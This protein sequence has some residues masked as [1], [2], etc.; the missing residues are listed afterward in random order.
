VQRRIPLLLLSAALAGCH[1]DSGD[2]RE[3]EIWVVDFLTHASDI[4]TTMTRVDLDGEAV[5]ERA[6]EYLRS[7]YYGIPIVFVRGLSTAD[8]RTSSICVRNTF[9]LNYGHGFLDVGNRSAVH[10]CGFEPSGL[11]GAFVN[12]VAD[13]Y[14]PQVTPTMTRNERT[15]AFAH[16]LGV[17][18]AHE[19]GH[20]LG[21]AH[22]TREFGAG[23]IM[24]SLPE[25]G[26]GQDHYF[27]EPH[28]QILALNVSR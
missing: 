4:E 28:R 25:F 5:A 15:D 11:L 12:R 3:A 22:S 6:M 19:I 17:V 20:G 26:F 18:L 13:A 2:P 16:I 7:Y 8:D 9:D 14:E 23:D 27:S 1:S 10:D 24:K 21:L